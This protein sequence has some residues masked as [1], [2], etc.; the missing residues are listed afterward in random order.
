MIKGTEDTRYA[1]VNGI[2]RALEAR[3]LTKGHF[4]RLVATDFSSYDTILSD[5]P[6]TGQ[7]DIEVGIEAEENA[8]R[9]F[10]D[11]YC[12]TEEVINFL[13]WPEQIHNLKVKLKGGGDDLLYT[14]VDDTIESW[15]E[16]V[17]EV[18]RFAIDKD[19]FVLST[20]LDKILC[21]YLYQAAQFVPFFEGYYRLHFEL[22]NIRSFFRARQ[23]ENRRHI[24]EQV[25][26]PV[27]RL[28]L[29]FLIEN[30]DV[31]QDNLGRNFFNTPYAGV[32]EKGGL[33]FEENNSFLRLER[34]CEENR[35]EYLLQARRMT[36]GV[37]P[38]FGY[39]Q[40]KM[41]E[42]RKL[43]QVYWGKLNEVGLEELKESIPD[44]W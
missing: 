28:E 43:R 14:Q 12:F 26:I 25:Y 29:N 1:Y 18:A 24:L 41:S 21:S 6:Y 32:V 34:L 4:D 39:Y 16:V 30:L 42:I 27:G 40:F 11:K 9:G 20:N 13:N 44:V 37:E 38:L 3:F 36:F 8:L 19:P 2:I 5:T 7:R 22:E 23:F 31:G 35:L 17:D 33:Y 15:P 10:F